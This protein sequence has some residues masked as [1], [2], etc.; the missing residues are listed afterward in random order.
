MNNNLRGFSFVA[1][2]AIATQAVFAAPARPGVTGDYRDFKV[3]KSYTA[4][5]GDYL[6]RAF[7]IEW[8]GQ[9]VVAR[10]ASSLIVKARSDDTINVLVSAGS[11]RA[12]ETHGNILFLARPEKK[13]PFR[14]EQVAA[15]NAEVGP[16]E[17]SRLV[18]AK[19]QRVYAFQDA[20]FVFRAY[21]VEWQGQ[22]VVVFDPL[23]RSKHEVG[24][25]ITIAVGR[26]P[27]LDAKQPHGI[28]SFELRLPPPRRR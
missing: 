14:R 20:S 9:E 23:R 26:R 3:L 7:V 1:T 28:L 10:D 24:D 6:F 12:G 13:P 11:T 17:Q 4:K 2:L 22:E 25:Q 5:D 21:E 15:R 27:P 19:V 8:E 18:E 16:L